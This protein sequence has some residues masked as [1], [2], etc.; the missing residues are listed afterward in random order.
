[1]ES[2]K[3]YLNNIFLNMPETEDVKRAKEELL[4]M[5]EDKYEE[6]ISEG[7][8]EEEA[9]GIVISEFGNF[10]ELAEE[11]G[12]EEYL[13]KAPGEN[14][15]FDNANAK[16]NSKK[17]FIKAK[18][19]YNWRK[20][21]VENYI[22]YAWA[23]ARMIALGVALCIFAGFSDTVFETMGDAIGVGTR[24]FDAI[25]SAAVIACIAIAIYFFCKASD[26]KKK[27][28]NIRK[29]SVAMDESAVSYYQTRKDEDD[30]KCV[31]FRTFGIVLCIVSVIPSCFSGVFSYYMPLRDI[32][33]SSILPIVAVGVFS[34]VY[35]CS[36]W[37]RYEDLKKA[38]K[39]TPADDCYEE[40]YRH[41]DVDTSKESKKVIGLVIVIAA[42]LTVGSI[43]ATTVLNVKEALTEGGNAI[44]LADVNQTYGEGTVKNIKVDIDFSKLVIESTDDSKVSVEG[45]LVGNPEIKMVDGELKIEEKSKKTF[46]ISS[47]FNWNTK[48]GTVTIK[49]PKTAIVNSYNLN[50]DAGDINIR[51]IETDEFKIDLDAGNFE[52]NNLKANQ[53]KVDVDAGNVELRDVLINQF[54]ADVDA[55]NC[56]YTSAEDISDYSIK[57]T[58]DLGE[59]RFMGDKVSGEYTKEGNNGKSINVKV[60]LG[61]I[62]I[63]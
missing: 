24:L 41:V 9:V 14:K 29:A 52:C 27:A 43:A 39:R 40:G 59:N 45:S 44:A 21:D 16:S 18:V 58:V 28:I 26:M 34:I 20:E 61:N 50:C 49:V 37:N 2:I 23:H 35:A 30:R 32:M 62:E 3:E 7:K 57:T 36:T 15:T 42:F 38:L 46:G 54:E 4:Q 1:M 12:I 51:D 48:S 55:G 47:L 33:D 8:S 5:M 6:L 31:R 60:S 53:A 25:G 63:K 22:D 19:G 13:N 56:E 11:L 17:T 10:E